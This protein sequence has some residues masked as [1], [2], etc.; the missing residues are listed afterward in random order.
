MLG[1]D[2]R[3]ATGDVDEVVLSKLGFL[4]EAGQR[5]GGRLGEERMKG[6]LLAESPSAF[7]RR[8]IFTEAEPLRR[9]RML[10]DGRWWGYE[11][12]RSG[13][14]PQPGEIIETS[15]CKDFVNSRSPSS[16]QC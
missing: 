16:Q 11:K 9:A 5:V 3:N 14:E 12:V 2:L 1:S 7:R 15:G 8:M 10:R 4:C 13:L 6:F